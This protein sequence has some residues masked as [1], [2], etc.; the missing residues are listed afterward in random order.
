MDSPLA[1][2]HEKRLA[3]DIFEADQEEDH[4]KGYNRLSCTFMARSTCRI[5][6]SVKF[7]A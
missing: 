6:A 3:C 1:A 2:V 7:P 4:T 5:S